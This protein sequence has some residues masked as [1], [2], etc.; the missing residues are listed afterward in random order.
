VIA[1][2]GW[3]TKVE[4]PGTGPSEELL[5]ELRRAPQDAVFVAAIAPR[6]KLTVKISMR[7]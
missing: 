3:K 5:G 7:R 2:D 4:P 1:S 6:T